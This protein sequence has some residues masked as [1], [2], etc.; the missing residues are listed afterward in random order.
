MIFSGM[1]RMIHSMFIALALVIGLYPSIYFLID[2]KFGLLSFKSDV[3]LNDVFWN[4]GFY[5]HIIFGGISLLTGWVQFSQSFREK[6]LTLHRNIG[7]IYIISVF[8]SSVSGIY[9]ALNATG[10]IIASAG[11]MVLGIIWFTATF[12]AFTAIRKQN[13]NMHRSMM[14]YSYSACFAAVTLRIWLPL[15]QLIFGNFI[16]AY[17]AVSWLCWVPNIFIAHFIIKKYPYDET[18]NNA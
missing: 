3:L 2:R 18:R 11:F 8:I 1:M 17:Q 10:G 13:L 16:T 6:H 5:S 7:K 4:F 9:I 14:I 12:S 15:L